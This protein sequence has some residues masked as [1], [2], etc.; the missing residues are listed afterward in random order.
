MTA[1]DRFWSKVAGD[2][3]EQCWLWQAATNNF[4]YGRFSV[5]GR[6]SGYVMAH[7]WAYEQMRADIPV[8]L[9]LDHLCQNP[10]CVNPWHLEPVSRRV[11][12][13]RGRLWESEKTHCAQ[14]HPYDNTNTRRTKRGHR[15][16]RTCT[17][18]GVR[19]WRAR[20]ALLAP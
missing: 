1:S 20:Q 15:A 12:A 18:E 11:N 10:T 13:L 14:G 16:C 19:R 6:A 7:R 4:G 2:S 3:V 9:V 8:Q 17:T 5:P